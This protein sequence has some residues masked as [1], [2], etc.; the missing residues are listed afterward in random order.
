MTVIPPVGGVSSVKMWLHKDTRKSAQGK[1]L[2]LPVAQRWKKSTEDR[3]G[4]HSGYLDIQIHSFKASLHTNEEEQRLDS[5]IWEERKTKQMFLECDLSKRNWFGDF[6][7]SRGNIRC[8]EPICHPK[9]MEMP[10]ASMPEPG[11]WTEDWYTTWQS[12]KDNPNTLVLH[13]RDEIEYDKDSSRGRIWETPEVGT[14]C[15]VRLKIGENVSRIHFEHTSSL[16]R[17]KWR[18][19]Y[20]PRGAFPYS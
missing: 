16:R 3:I 12:R 8:H 2:R 1:K 13:E 4:E 20:F 14:I 9:S 17:S 6:V 18:R 19:K 5:V 11:E 10:M 15:S 7:N